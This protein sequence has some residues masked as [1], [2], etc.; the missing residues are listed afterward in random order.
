MYT[1]ILV[2]LDGSRLAEQVLPYVRLLGMAEGVRVVLQRVIEPA[3]PDL[4]GF[5][6]RISPAEITANIAGKA[7]EYLGEVAESLKGKGLNVSCLVSEGAPATCIADE[8]NREA[9][10]LIAM[11]THGYSG[12]TRWVM[13][14]VSDKVL[15]ATSNPLL[16]IC[17]KEPE[18]FRQDAG[19]QSIIVPLDQ[20]SMAEQVLPHVT[21]LAKALELKVTVVSVTPPADAYYR[22]AEYATANWDDLAMEVDNQATDYLHQVA[23]KLRLLGVTSVEERLLHGSAAGAIVDLAR[24]T[25]D[26][27]VMMTTHGRSGLGRWVLG[28]VADRIIRNSG[29]PVLVVRAEEEATD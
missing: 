13:G 21:S 8:A 25:P 23:Q 27:L 4:I 18:E 9:N 29:D 28:S 1:R 6:Q 16:I 12:V 2:P 7:Q 22:Y 24:E 26:N 20:S 15:H 5:T 10:T 11:C 3:P 17:V 14:S 19:L